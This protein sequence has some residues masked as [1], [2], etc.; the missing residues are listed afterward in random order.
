MYQCKL[1]VKTGFLVQS[2]KHKSR[3][4]K[5]RQ[6]IIVNK[7]FLKLLVGVSMLS[8]VFVLVAIFKGILRHRAY[9]TFL[10]D[11]V[12]VLAKYVFFSCSMSSKSTYRDR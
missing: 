1:A 8:S 10:L 7:Y 2:C 4:A 9:S 6:Q 11:T 12:V 3:S 5:S